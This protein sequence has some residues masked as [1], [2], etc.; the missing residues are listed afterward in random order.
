[1]PVATPD[2]FLSQI[3]AEIDRGHQLANPHR[4]GQIAK[5]F[6]EPG[7]PFAAFDMIVKPIDWFQTASGFV[8][9]AQRVVQVDVDDLGRSGSFRFG[10]QPL[11]LV[12]SQRL[13]YLV[14]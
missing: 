7:F 11:D 2:S 9:F 1:M 5:P 10:Q 6:L 8:L 14:G 3:Q 12:Y 4:A 13:A